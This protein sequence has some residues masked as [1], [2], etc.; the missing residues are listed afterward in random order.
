MERV[1]ESRLLYSGR[2]VRLRVDRV[3]LEETEAEVVREVVEHGESVVAVPITP[4]REVVLVRQFRLP[5]GRDLLEAPAGGMEPGEAPEEAVRRE[6]E[7]ETGYRAGR[8]V[9]LG[10]FWVSPGYCTEYMHAF[11][12]LDLEP[13]P[14]R[15]EADEAIQVVRV[16]LEQVPDL[17]RRGEVQDAKTLSALLMAL[18]LHPDALP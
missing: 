14:T 7:E 2:V 11:L 9:P 1:L 12:A 6:L 3:R 4:R 16:P 18:H 10:G 15:P 5:A 17:L 8:L 13:G